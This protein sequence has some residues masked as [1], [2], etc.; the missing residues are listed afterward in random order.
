MTLGITDIKN[1][2]IVPVGIEIW[3]QAMSDFDAAALLIVPVGIEI[4][5]GFKSHEIVENF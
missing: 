3:E 1:L 5:M 2:L 4:Q